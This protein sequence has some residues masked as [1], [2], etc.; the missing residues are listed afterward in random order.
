MALKL[1]NISD[2]SAVEAGESVMLPGGRHRKVRLDVNTASRTHITLTT[3]Q[4]EICFLGVV[5]GLET[6]EF[7]AEGNLRLDFV[8]SDDEATWIYTADGQQVAV[9]AADQ[10]PYTKPHQRRAR[11]P[12]I[13]HLAMKMEQ[14]MLRNMRV[15][16]ED[17]ERRLARETTKE[18]KPDAKRDGHPAGKDGGKADGNTS[19]P[20][21]SDK[22]PLLDADK[23][24][25]EQPAGDKT[26]TK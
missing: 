5:D 3:E 26:A 13:E 22:G 18:A 2:W 8:N 25:A 19:E 9:Y 10:M 1:N 7:A 4:G 14:N 17:L 23:P 24:T 11:N 16:Q 12:E 15:M 21:A 20:D 6:L